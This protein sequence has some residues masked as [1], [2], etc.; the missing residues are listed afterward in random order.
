M[1]LDP[2]DLHPLIVNWGGGVNST[3]MLVGM[4]ER[5]IRPDR[6][7]FADTWAEKPETYEF[8]WRSEDVQKTR[9]RL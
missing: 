7:I 4:L 1:R 3:A 8:A 5:D 6:I 9:A 2:D